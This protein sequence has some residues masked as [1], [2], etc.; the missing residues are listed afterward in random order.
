MG[1]ML[2]ALFTVSLLPAGAAA[3]VD[4]GQRF[5]EIE[6]AIE[7]AMDSHG[8]LGASVAIID[9]FQIVYA[10][11]F[12]LA[13]P[14][15]AVEADTL[16]QAASLTKPVSAVV[17]AAAA[18][19]GLVDL[20][21]NV[22]RMLTSW[23]LPPFPY[24]V[25]V[26]LRMLLAHR[27][28]TNVPGFPGYRLDEPLP[29]LPQILDGVR[30]KN[31]PI[32]VVT[33]PG[34]QR[35]YS[36]GGFLVAQL[37]IEDH[38]G[39]TWEDLAER[40]VFEPL[41]LELSTYRILDGSARRRVA[42]GYR[43]DGAEVAGGGWHLYPETA[44]AS[45]WTTPSEY[46]AFVIDVMRSYQDGTGVVLDRATARLLLDPDF[47]VGF[48]VSREEGSISIGHDGANEGYRCRFV[49]L[50][51]LGEGVVVMTNSD[52]GDAVDSAVVD[53]VAEE[54]GWP[55]GGWATPLWVVVA[56]FALIA[57]AGLSGWSRMTRRR[58]A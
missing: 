57:L 55:R 30:E 41:G 44:A 50:P 49:A 34:A 29:E 18:E 19:E 51:R 38:T 21:V 52:S 14:G 8:V 27:A 2:A 37:A 35:N 31:E 43:P 7:E 22:D 3:S 17:A 53:A 25:P 15:R 39:R 28:G 13:E 16:F 4:P 12:G 45:L 23:R 47:S 33:E 10:R 5:M 9:D 36:G 46:A 1:R 54:L 48:G 20:D 42:V 40:L 11:G 26:T 32:R 58:R 6:R 56:L 24:D